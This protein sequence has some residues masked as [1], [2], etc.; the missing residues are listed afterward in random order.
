MR[1]KLGLL[2]LIKMTVVQR[3]TFMI[4]QLS[5]IW[6]INSVQ[7]VDMANSVSIVQLLLLVE[8][9][10]CDLKNLNISHVK[11]NLISS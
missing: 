4:L 1:P 3:K 8:C 9:L 5:C 2:K 11:A 7:F 6:T 10:C